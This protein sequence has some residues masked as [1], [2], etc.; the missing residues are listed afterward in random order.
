MNDAVPEAWRP[1]VAVAV[2]L[3]A[4]PEDVFV[5]LVHPAGF[6][7]S[8][9]AFSCRWRRPGIGAVRD[10]VTVAG[11]FREEITAIDP[12]HVIEYRVQRSVPPARQEH[13]RITVKPTDHGTRVRWRIC[14]E[15]RVPVIGRALTRMA[16]PLAKALYAGI[17][18][19]GSRALSS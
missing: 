8:S 15:V 7:R 5:W 10:L 9:L 17:L 6:T 18:H 12:G 2:D 1:N 14:F 3:D 19:A 4:A 16:S 13:A 11:W